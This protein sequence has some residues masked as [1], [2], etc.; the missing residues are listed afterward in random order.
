[1]CICICVY[2]H[3]YVCIFTHIPRRSLQRCRPAAVSEKFAKFRRCASKGLHRC[4]A[5][6]SACM[7]VCMCVY[8]CMYICVCMY[9]YT[10]IY[11]HIYIYVCICI[12]PW[13]CHLAPRWCVYIYV[14]MYVYAFMPSSQCHFVLCRD[15]RMYTQ[16]HMRVYMQ[17]TDTF[18]SMHACIY[19]HLTN[20]H[21]LHVH[22]SENQFSKRNCCKTHFVHTCITRIYIYI[23]IPK[24]H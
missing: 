3:A 1:M 9:V 4:V 15:A 23:H 5:L 11:T 21:I 13:L 6:L 22:T 19:T 7:C 8:V 10:S 16:P 2:T 18:C 17:F 24:S 20:T 14:C 12:P